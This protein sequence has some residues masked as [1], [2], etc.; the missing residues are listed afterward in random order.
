MMMPQ[1]AQANQNDRYEHWE[2]DTP[3]E[4]EHHVVSSLSARDP[5]LP[6]QAHDIRPFKGGKNDQFG[7]IRSARVPGSQK[8]VVD[9]LHQ[10]LQ[11]EEQNHAGHIQLNNS[12]RQQLQNLTL[13]STKAFEITCCR[14]QKCSR[15]IQKRLKSPSVPVEE[16]QRFLDRILKDEAAS[17]D[18]LVQDSF[19]NYVIQIVQ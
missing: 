8:H 19:G 12:Q 13:D 3:A 7:P 9:Q 2:R 6:M 11:L 16:K 1:G 14:D 15:F 17:F 5:V 4:I 18:T 10:L